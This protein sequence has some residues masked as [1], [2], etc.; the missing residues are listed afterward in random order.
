[1]DTTQLGRSDDP[2]SQRPKFCSGCGQPASAGRFCAHCGIALA[3]SVTPSATPLVPSQP[4]ALPSDE[5][6][7]VILSRGEPGLAAPAGAAYEPAVH[8]DL[9]GDQPPF[10]LT[11]QD[12]DAAPA[13][14]RSSR[15]RPLL[16]SGV[17]LAVGVIAA[18]AVLVAGYV[19]DSGMRNALASSTRDFNAV[20]TS[21]TTA[22]DA[23]AVATAADSAEPAADRIDSALQRLGSGSGP[24]HRSV[25]AQL[26]A[27]QGVLTAVAG[28]AAISS[29]PLA[30]WG[31][32]HDDLTDALATETASRDT[33]ALH[34]DGAAANLSDPSLMLGKVTAAVGPALVDDATDNSAR[35]LKSLQG[36]TSTAD[37]RK[38]GD[39]AAPEQAAVS[40]AAAALPSGDGKQVLTGYAAALGAL[41]D[42]SRITAE[43][44]AGWAGTRAELAGTFG[45]VAA[46]AGS[47]GGA[48]VRVVL[49]GALDSA[50]KVVAAAAAAIADWKAKTDAA[51]KDREADAENLESYASFFRSQAKTYEQLRQDLSGFTARVEDPNADV[52]YFEAYEFLSQAAQDRRNVRDMMVGM[53]VPSGVRG[54]HQEMVSAID[55]AI[56]A[57]QS[58][59]D[60]LE[61]SQDCYY[62]DECP[63]YRDTPGWTRF[64]SE[65]D[66]ISKQYTKAVS[67]WEAAAAAEK[68]AVTNRALPAKPQV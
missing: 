68:G 62:Y 42:L 28:L 52:S 59:Y 55:R 26:E 54:A 36:V 12:D 65:S 19:G 64:Q 39:A 18:G 38:L 7:T 27:E 67:G 63:Y 61:Q 43:S 44:T 20:M 8:G 6:P 50:D 34:H 57:V 22:A 35:L 25:V 53:D 1:M 4:S 16:I 33:L 49:D 29:D 11:W 58:A 46:A 5:Q 56:S 15:R 32:A 2:V 60:G 37:L 47:T 51:V 14:G 21:L 13:P 23:D 9:H 10:D 3:A 40:A 31:A 24:A 48:S 45:Q 41:A 30:T 17:V 66:A